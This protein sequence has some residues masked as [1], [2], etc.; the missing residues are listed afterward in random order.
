MSVSNFDGTIDIDTPSFAVMNDARYYLGRSFITGSFLN[1]NWSA[2]IS[3]QYFQVPCATSCSDSCTTKKRVVI[4]ILVVLSLG[5]LA[6]IANLVMRFILW[7]R[8]QI[9]THEE[10]KEIHSPSGNLKKLDGHSKDFR[11]RAA[12]NRKKALN[13]L[14]EEERKRW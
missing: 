14:Q 1:G 6:I 11:K 5:L 3:S 7:K 10:F 8:G 2:Y 9:V 13:E 12:E 4:A